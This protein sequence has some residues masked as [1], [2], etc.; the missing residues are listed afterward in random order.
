MRA[1]PQRAEL[2]SY[3]YR[4]EPL[5]HSSPPR[6]ALSIPELKATIHGRVISP[7]DANY[8][9]ARTVFV[10]GVDRRPAVIVRVAD[11]ADVVAVISM[12]RETGSELAVRSGGHSNGGLGVSEGRIVLDL[13]EV[14]SLE[15]DVEGRT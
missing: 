6:T 7:E 11:E 2:R 3:P 12:A 10:G 5:V 1:G 9:E 4:K 15:I 8:D 13:P 14:R